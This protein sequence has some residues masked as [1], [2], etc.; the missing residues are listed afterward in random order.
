MLV[1][2][3][4]YER[5]VNLGNY[6]NEKLGIDA[7]IEPGETTQDAIM[8]VRDQVEQGLAAIAAARRVEEDKALEDHRRRMARVFPPS[9][10]LLPGD[11]DTDEVP[12]DNEQ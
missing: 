9:A 2:T 7:E 1:K 5:L 10:P 3:I 4:H 12:S 11:F 6:Q 8:R